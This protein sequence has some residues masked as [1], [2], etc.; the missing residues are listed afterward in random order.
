M[1]ESLERGAI[2]AVESAPGAEPHEPLRVLRDGDVGVAGEAVIGSEA[3]D[4]VVGQGVRV[5]GTGLRLG[6]QASDEAEGEHEQ[7][8][9]FSK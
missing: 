6:L 4:V 9:L 2:V 1:V 8:R 3:L 5:A 7:K